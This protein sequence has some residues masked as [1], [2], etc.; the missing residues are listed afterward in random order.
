VLP[1]LLVDG[2]VAGVWR[3][4]GGKIEVTAFH[5][6]PD[7]AWQ[8]LAGEARGLLSLLATRQVAVYARYSH[9]WSTLP[10]TERRRLPED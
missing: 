3:P 2:Y 4:D 9:W 8:S 6:L 10:S 5:S 1:T 7:E